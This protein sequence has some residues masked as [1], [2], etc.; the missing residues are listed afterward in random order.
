MDTVI[1]LT[2][3]Y[4]EFINAFDPL[5]LKSEKALQ[6]IREKC[7]RLLKAFQDIVT[8]VPEH[9][10][11][12]LM[13][14]VLSRIQETIENLEGL[15]TVLSESCATRASQLQ[16]Y[17]MR[18]TRNFSEWVHWMEKC[19]LAGSEY[20]LRW[21]SLAPTNYYRNVF[22]LANAL[23]G[24]FL[25]HFFLTKEL[26]LGIMITI[27]IVFMTLDVSRRLSAKWNEKLLSLP[28][29]RH[30][31]R[32]REWQQTPSSCYYAAGLIFS[33]IFFPKVAVELGV[34]VL[35]FGDPAASIIGKRIRSRKLY[36]EKSLAGSTAF[37][38]VS[39]LASFLYLGFF[40]SS[41]Y[42]IG[43]IL[44]LTSVA[45]LAGMLGELF[46]RYIDDN[47]TIVVTAS[48]GVWLM[49]MIL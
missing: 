44:A 41:Y 15:L 38:T 25:Y 9:F 2:N 40:Y 24:V 12:T 30:M 48:L 21:K 8:E 32:P 33:L 29:F 10:D 45:A 35:G 31:V 47:F 49:T 34:L 46:S 43:A 1:T 18:L 36:G 26:A 14:A 37:F 16:D 23:T 20:V 5:L 4:F 42:S 17:H 28:L 3:E 6:Q 7:H 13:E 39:L 22:H 27:L 19:S 11:K